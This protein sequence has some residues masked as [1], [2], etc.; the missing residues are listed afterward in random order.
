MP[1][2]V[3][4][5][6]ERFGV[7]IPEEGPNEARGVQICLHLCFS[8]LSRVPPNHHQSMAENTTFSS[9][10]AEVISRPVEVT[11]DDT[12]DSLTVEEFEAYYDIDRTVSKIVEG[13]YKRVRS[14]IRLSFTSP[15]SNWDR[16]HYNSL[17]SSCMIRHPFFVR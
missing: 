12:A 16:L 9:S 7:R 15:P 5:L 1:V 10:G 11:T 6:T 3:E 14:V 17:M 2:V 4:G 13:D 8:H